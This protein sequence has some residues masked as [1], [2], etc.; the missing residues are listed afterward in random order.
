METALRL[1]REQG[2]DRTT[3]RAIAKEAGV[4][5]GNAYY[6]FESKEHLIQGFYDQ[7]Q[8]T[9]LRSC[10]D[11]LAS[12]Q[13]FAARLRGVLHIWLD[14]A[15]P[16]HEFAAQFFKNAADPTSPLSPFSPASEP[17]RSAN[18]AMQERVLA[19]SDAKPDAT[20]RPELPGLLWLYHMG[21]V[22]F[23]VHDR[24][25]NS[26]R[27]RLLV[28][29]TVPMLDRLVRLSRLPVLRS[30]TR[31]GVQLLKDLGWVSSF[32]SVGTKRR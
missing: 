6:Y 14:I 21:I 28:D 1:F 29:R 7:M 22:L 9:Y 12:E 20:L 4:S 24:S 13:G 3:M 15:E 2:Y 30:V 23:W 8:A 31:D 17:A 16:Y 32:T 18:I 26:A 10:T 11:L 27:T 5:V 19:G 25:T